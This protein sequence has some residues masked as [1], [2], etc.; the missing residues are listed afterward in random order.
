MHV[1]A[2]QA[3][4]KVGLEFVRDVHG[5]QTEHVQGGELGWC[6]AVDVAVETRR[7]H[8]GIAVD[9][10]VCQLTVPFARYGIGVAENVVAVDAILTGLFG[11]IAR[12]DEANV[13]VKK[14]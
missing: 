10:C 14:A 2:E 1:K 3:S 6:F 13:P 5:R 11:P 8:E 4:G 7:G 12:S 9:A